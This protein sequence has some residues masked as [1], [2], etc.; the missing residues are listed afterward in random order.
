MIFFYNEYYLH[1]VMFNLTMFPRVAYTFFSKPTIDTE[2]QDSAN[3][4]NIFIHVNLIVEHGNDDKST[5][6]LSCH[7]LTFYNLYIQDS[8]LYIQ[9]SNLYI[10][11]SNL[12]IQDSNLYI[13]DSNLYIQDS[14]L[15]IQDS[16]LYIQNNSI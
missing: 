9:D 10:Q 2:K 13:Q 12:Y 7:T 8:N 5:E 15:Y 16:N 14:N 1:Q 3:T 4:G 11:Y 6:A